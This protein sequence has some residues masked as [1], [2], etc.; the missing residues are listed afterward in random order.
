MPVQTNNKV[1]NLYKENFKAENMS[2]GQFILGVMLASLLSA[3]LA[4]GGLK[5]FS[6]EEASSQNI[7]EQN[8]NVRFSS[9]YADTGASSYVVPE[10]LN[11]I[12]AA[13][14]ATPGVV[15]I[16]SNVTREHGGSGGRHPYEEFFR[17]FFGDPHH[18]QNQRQPRRGPGAAGSGVIISED[19]YIVTNNH[20]IDG[21]DKIDIT[22]DDNRR[23]EAHVVGTDPT[24][25]LAVLKIEETGLHYLKFGSS[26][27]L[28][29]GEWVLAVGNPFDL[30]STVTAGI[31]SAK[32]RN[33]NI[34]QGQYR[35]ESFIQTDAAVNPGNSGGA[36][37]NLNGELVGVNTAIATPTGAYAGY[38]FAVPS[39]IVK[40]V[41]HDI[42]EYG[43]VQRALLGIQIAD[44][45]ATLAEE[46]GLKNVRGV[47]VQAVSEGSSADNAGIKQ[48]DV[49]IAIDDKKVNSTAQLQSQIARHRPGDEVEVTIIRNNKEKKVKA[50]LK[51]AQG[52]TSTVTASVNSLDLAGASFLDL[53]KGELKKLGI[54]GGVKINKIGSGKFKAAGIKE[55]FVIT[56]IDKKPVNSVA[57]LK[58]ALDNSSGGILI[59]GIYPN[60]QKAFY[61]LGW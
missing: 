41:A 12:Q 29:V 36:L 10:G 61:G 43:V 8:R 45:N 21:A 50:T 15:H 37:V 51:N 57:D 9:Y 17:E 39:S 31:I 44:V 47:F 55:G 58:R 25:D 46:K 52:D 3:I 60:G 59:E 5:F 4:I 32:S 24:T 30:N 27:A 35:I 54:N 13:E 40:K 28:K 23:Y 53:D 19:G 33:I 56:S 49:I 18:H 11:F 34:L 16:R 14:V 22:L 7:E 2:K 20:V 6:E 1:N 38:A 42:M 26:D 48:G